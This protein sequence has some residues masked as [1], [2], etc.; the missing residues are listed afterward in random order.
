MPACL[1]ELMIDSPSL[2]M[3]PLVSS[4]LH[5]IFQRQAAA[6]RRLSI[7]GSTYVCDEAWD[8][9]FKM[10]VLPVL[11][12]LRIDFSMQSLKLISRHRSLTYLEINELH[13]FTSK[14]LP[15]PLLPNLTYLDAFPETVSFFLSAPNTFPK[16]QFIR[17][18]RQVC[19]T[20]PLNSVIRALHSIV[21]THSTKPLHITVA[22]SLP[23]RTIDYSSLRSQLS[24]EHSSKGSLAG[25]RSPNPQ[26][27]VELIL[28]V[29]RSWWMDDAIVQGGLEDIVSWISQFR[30]LKA[31]YVNDIIFHGWDINKRFCDGIVAACP[32][33]DVFYYGSGMVKGQEMG[34]KVGNEPSVWKDDGFMM[35]RKGT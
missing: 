15:E 35:I 4:Y 5:S 17:M 3:N 23:E 32:H 33:L 19:P 30:S 8:Q 25:H 26:R 13:S 28:D 12:S 20:P 1:E 6:I 16:L 10:V 24:P 27:V 9:L 2:Q 14:R 34:L 29:R 11:E 21:S 18:I 7:G 22:I 31:L